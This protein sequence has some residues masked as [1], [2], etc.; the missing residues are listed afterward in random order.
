MGKFCWLGEPAWPGGGKAG[1]MP[2]GGGKPGG[3]KLGGIP[4]PAPPGAGGKP[5]GTGGMPAI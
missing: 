1:G 3:G 5:G 4:R 2:F